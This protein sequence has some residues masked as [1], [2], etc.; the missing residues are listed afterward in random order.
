[1]YISLLRSLDL[2]KGAEAI[3]VS[4]LTAQEVLR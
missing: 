2:G 4:C 3:N 1:M